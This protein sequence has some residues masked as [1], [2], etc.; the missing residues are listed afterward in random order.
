M[1]QL[2]LLSHLP[3]P[4]EEAGLFQNVNIGIPDVL[5]GDP[6]SGENV[7][8]IKGTSTCGSRIVSH[9]GSE[10]GRASLLPSRCKMLY[11]PI[12]FPLRRR[13]APAG[14]GGNLSFGQSS[15][16]RHGGRLPK[17]AGSHLHS[18]LKMALLEPLRGAAVVVEKSG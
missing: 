10:P 11:R 14:M 5:N 4:T 12:T 13:K 9:P 18:L 15:C 8:A 17:G 6:W 1:P 16:H 2:Q 7:I 3:N